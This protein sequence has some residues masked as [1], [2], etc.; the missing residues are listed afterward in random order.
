MKMTAKQ[1]RSATKGFEPEEYDANLDC[2]VPYIA[3]V[4]RGVPIPKKIT[5]EGAGFRMRCTNDRCHLA[6][7]F[8]LHKKCS[9]KLEENL[10]KI[11][12]NEGS[13]RG[14]TDAQLRSNLWEKKGQSLV[15]RILRCRCGMGVMS[16]DVDFYKKQMV[17]ER[18]QKTFAD[19]KVVQA[20]K[21]AKKSKLPAVNYNNVRP[22]PLELLSND[23]PAKPSEHSPHQYLNGRS[24]E[25]ESP[26]SQQ[27][28]ITSSPTPPSIHHEQQQRLFSSGGSEKHVDEHRKKKSYGNPKSAQS[29]KS[30]RKSKLSTPNTYNNVRPVQLDLIQQN[31]EFVTNGTS[32]HSPSLSSN[33]YLS[34]RVER[35][36]P[37]TNSKTP[38]TTPSQTPPTAPPL[39][40][41]LQQQQQNLGGNNNNNIVNGAGDIQVCFF[42]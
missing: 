9:D 34:N 42:C 29:K 14:W 38:M 4:C 27:T 15:G 21:A 28:T 35:E 24:L 31:N 30:S 36:S 33:Q 18:K 22:V 6:S 23:F 1:R 10:L 19:P 3:C 12:A 17:E 11:L 13:A 25:R 41:D 26:S 8:F 20:K 39:Q 40:N 32:E 2:P 5:D 7:S 37:S 16:V